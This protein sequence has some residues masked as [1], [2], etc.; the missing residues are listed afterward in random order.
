MNRIQLRNEVWRR[1]EPDV[2]RIQQVLADR[3]L[4]ATSDQ[5][6]WIWRDFSDDMCAEWNALPDSDDELFE[7]V[8]EYFDVIEE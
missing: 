8:Q 7:I 3:K 4:N 5:C 6:Y 1:Y 2:L